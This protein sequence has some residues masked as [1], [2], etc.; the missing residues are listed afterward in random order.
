LKLTRSGYRWVDGSL[1]GA[2]YEGDYWS[3]N[4]ADGGPS[5]AFYLTGSEAKTAGYDPGY[6]I[7]VRCIKD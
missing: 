5:W 6:G 4:V 1:G 2:D 7:S 3:S